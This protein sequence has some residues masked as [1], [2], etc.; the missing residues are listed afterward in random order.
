M[1]YIRLD[2]EI[3]DIAR[4][5]RGLQ[6]VQ[7]LLKQFGSM[8]NTRP[9]AYVKVIPCKHHIK[10]VNSTLV[11]LLNT[12]TYQ[13]LNG[14]INDHKH[15]SYKNS[16]YHILFL[17]PQNCVISLT[18]ATLPFNFILCTLHFETLWGQIVLDTLTQ[19]FLNP[20]LALS[21][22][23][24]KVST[25]RHP[26][27]RACSFQVTNDQTTPSSHG[28]QSLQ[29][30]QLPNLAFSSSLDIRCSSVQKMQWQKIKTMTINQL[31]QAIKATLNMTF[32]LKCLMPNRIV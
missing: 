31:K 14:V 5:T 1:L 17:W 20:T 6:N 15:H 32:W 26:I 2:T 10:C 24:L 13:F 23:H 28:S 4:L 12:K 8:T 22:I 3:N 11:G 21:P 18:W 30:S 9:S 16:K 29:P 25:S 19:C 27:L 7:Q